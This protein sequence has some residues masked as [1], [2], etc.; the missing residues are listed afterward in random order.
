M[1]QTAVW[2]EGLAVKPVADGY[3]VDSANTKFSRSGP[4]ENIFFSTE[5]DGGIY[6]SMDDYLKW[7][8]ALQ[9]GKWI[10][11]KLVARERSMQYM[12]DKERR[13]GYGYGWFIDD[14]SGDKKVY[15][16]G[17]NGGYRAYSFSIPLQNFLIVIFSNRSDIDL[18]K[19]VL[20]ITH[21]L[22]PAD[23]PFIPIIVLTS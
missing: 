1:K 23:Q 12:I 13:S 22:G 14:H 7:F 2:S 20:K 21:L 8:N 15:H 5:G 17:S 16:S 9:A 4:D 10:S 3:D 19:I 11:K 6:T 18:E